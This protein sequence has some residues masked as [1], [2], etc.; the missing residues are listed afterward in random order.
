MVCMQ[1]ITET[2]IHETQLWHEYQ[3]HRPVTGFQNP[4]RQWKTDKK[5]RNSTPAVIMKNAGIGWGRGR[6][7]VI[8]EEAERTSSVPADMQNLTSGLNFGGNSLSG[9]CMPQNFNLPLQRDNEKWRPSF[10]RGTRGL[11]EK[12]MPNQPQVYNVQQAI[13]R[14]ET[15]T[16]EKSRFNQ[17]ETNL[18]RT[19]NLGRGETQSP[20]H[21]ANNNVWRATSFGRGEAQSAWTLKSNQVANNNVWRQTGSASGHTQAAWT[22]SSNE[23][24]NSNVWRAT[25]SGIGERR[26][27][28]PVRPNQPTNN[29]QWESTRSGRPGNWRSGESG[30][31]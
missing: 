23:R 9:R 19:R 29:N 14:G 27:G 4:H 12:F 10:G 25:N 13:R 16:A 3:G 1:T 17:P 8:S 2:D 7:K 21:P 5:V 26:A 20:N 18:S 22:S 15:Q 6:G 11:T 31:Q 24:T 28:V 30:A